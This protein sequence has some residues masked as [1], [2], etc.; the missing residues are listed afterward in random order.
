MVEDAPS[1]KVGPLQTLACCKQLKLKAQIRPKA[2]TSALCE[3]AE[4]D[5][6]ASCTSEALNGVVP[7]ANVEPLAALIPHRGA[8]DP[9]SLVE[10]GLCSNET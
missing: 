1:P 9:V 6:P 10:A 4:V 7:V 2:P 5:F 8:W 3:S